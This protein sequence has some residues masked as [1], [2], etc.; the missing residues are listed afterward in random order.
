MSK[1]TGPFYITF[2]K[3]MPRNVEVS[4]GPAPR[5]TMCLTPAFWHY[6]ITLYFGEHVYSISSNNKDTINVSKSGICV[7]SSSKSRITVSIPLLVKELLF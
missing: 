4:S 6:P 7:L 1:K 2:H 5:C 3:L